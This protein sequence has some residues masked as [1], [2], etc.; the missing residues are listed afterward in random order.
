M[1]WRKTDEIPDGLSSSVGLDSDVTTHRVDRCHNPKDR[2]LL[3]GRFTT[4]EHYVVTPMLPHLVFDVV[5]QLSKF[6][7]LLAGGPTGVPG[8]TVDVTPPTP[9]VAGIE[10][11]EH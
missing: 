3:K 1:F 6:Y 5:K 8:I 4:S 10:T 7:S 9:Q 2:F 11:N